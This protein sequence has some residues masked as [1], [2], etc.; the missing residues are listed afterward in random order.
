MSR[1]EIHRVISISFESN[2]GRFLF[3]HVNSNKFSLKRVRN[4]NN[5]IFNKI[6]M[7]S[8]NVKT[9]EIKTSSRLDNKN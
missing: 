3:I 7:I 2:K 5:T 4:C 9:N 6:F 1:A 8:Y